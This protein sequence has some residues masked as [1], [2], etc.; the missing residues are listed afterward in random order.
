MQSASAV[1]RR[2]PPGLP[3]F[4]PRVRAGAKA[5]EAAAEAAQPDAGP[6]LADP[7]RKRRLMKQPLHPRLGADL[8]SSSRRR[9]PHRCSA[10]RARRRQTPTRGSGERADATRRPIASLHAP[11]ERS[12]CFSAR[13]AAAGLDSRLGWH[14]APGRDRKD[15]SRRKGPLGSMLDR[16]SGGIRLTAPALRVD[17]VRVGAHPCPSAGA[18]PRLLGERSLPS[19]PA[20]AQDRRDAATG[21]I[22]SST[23]LAGSASVPARPAGPPRSA[24]PRATALR[25]RA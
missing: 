19:A 23:R 2:A 21:A 18:A 8:P 25:R 7:R 1:A 11:F 9:N 17:S 16:R 14:P 22:T 10:A 5:G 4:L 3:A 12:P 15:G 20:T 6:D 13:I 24:S